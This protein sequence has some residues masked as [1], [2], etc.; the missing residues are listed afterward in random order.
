MVSRNVD[1]WPGARRVGMEAFRKVGWEQLRGELSDP[2]GWTKRQER[3]LWRHRLMRTRSTRARPQERSTEE[4]VKVTRPPCPE[5]AAKWLTGPRAAHEAAGR[6]WPWTP[7]VSSTAGR[8][9]LP[10]ASMARMAT[11]RWALRGSVKCCTVPAAAG[12]S[13]TDSP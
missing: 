4:P 10:W 2:P 5:A 13:F 9:R 11:Y 3:P 1:G 7:N 12:F 8:P 6:A